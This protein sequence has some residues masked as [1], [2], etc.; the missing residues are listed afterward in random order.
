M[1]EG[2]TKVDLGA[3]V[4]LT[5]DCCRYIYIYT[6]STKVDFRSKFI[7]V[8]D[9]RFSRYM[10]IYDD[11][12]IYSNIYIY[13]MYMIYPHLLPR[14]RVDN[15]ALCVL[16][17]GFIGNHGKPFREHTVPV[18]WHGRNFFHWVWSVELTTLQGHL[19]ER[20]AD[21]ATMPF[22]FHPD[23]DQT[24]GFKNYI[25]TLLRWH[26]HITSPYYPHITIPKSGC[27]WIWLYTSPYYIHDNGLVGSAQ[28]CF[29]V[30]VVVKHPYK[31]GHPTPH[32]PLLQQ[33]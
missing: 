33:A 26:P 24:W 7:K 16:A 14:R 17:D 23:S 19:H 2:V 13:G 8:V 9:F 31:D 11:I 30:F 6:H 32:G 1:P 28:F 21:N 4:H 27:N 10:M 5:N 20:V 29:W 22:R 15:N 25:L 3:R 18:W 12:W